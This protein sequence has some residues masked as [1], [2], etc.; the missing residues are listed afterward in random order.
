[1]LKHMTKRISAL[2]LILAFITSTLTACASSNGGE[3][4]SLFETLTDWFTSESEED[5]KGEETSGEE[6]GEEN[7]GE[8]NVT[9][10]T[11][12]LDLYLIA[13]QSNAAGC[14]R[15]TDLNAAYAWSSEL[16]DGFSNVLYAGNSRSNGAAP[17]D[18]VIAW[19]KTTMGLGIT[20]SNYFGPEA[21]MAVALSDYY[22]EET[23]KFAG[24]IKYAYG[25]SSLLN[26]T[27]DDTSKDGN[28]V[29]PSY[30]KT[31]PASQVVGATGQMYRNFLEQVR[32]NVEEVLGQSGNMEEY[33]FDSVRICGLYWMQ[34]CQ[35]K[36]QPD[37]YEKAFKYF[38]KDIRNDLSAIMK[39]ITCSDDDCGATDMPIIVGTISNTQNLTSASTESVNRT[40]IS[41][42]KSFASKIENC[43]VVDNSSYVITKWE[44]NR[45]VVVGSDQWHWN[46]TDMLSIGI[47][48]GEKML[49]CAGHNIDE[50]QLRIV[51]IRNAGQLLA[52]IDESRL[53]NYANS[54]KNTVYQLQNDIDLNEGWSAGVTAEG[55]VLTDLPTAPDVIWTGIDKFYGTLD[56]NGYTVKGIYM[57]KKLDS[58]SSMGFI[59]E[60]CGGTVRNLT[61]DNCYI[62]ASVDSSAS[63]VNIGV[64][65]G[66]ADASSVIDHVTV[67]A[68][69]YI[70]GNENV[71]ASGTVAG[72]PAG[73]SI[74]SSVVFNGNVYKSAEDISIIEV[75]TA[76][77][78]LSALAVHGDFG[79][80]T[81]KLMSNI[82]LNPGWN[83]GVTIDS[84]VNAPST[85]TNLWPDIAVFKGT[86][87]GNGYTLSGIYS[88]KTVSQNGA[89]MAVGGLFNTL[90]G[91]TV[92]NIKIVNSFIL[93]E[94]VGWGNTSLHVGGIAG[95]VNAG[96]TVSCVYFD[97]EI[98][99]KSW[100][101]CYL[102]GIF[103]FANGQYT[104]NGLVFVGRIGYTGGGWDANYASSTAGKEMYISK[105]IVD[106]NFYS[107]ATIT[108]SLMLGS[109]Y[110]KVNKADYPQHMGIYGNPQHFPWSLKYVLLEKLDAAWLET[111]EDYM[112]AGFV[113]SENLGCCIPGEVIELVKDIDA[114]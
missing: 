75:Y 56:G 29:S 12:T 98:W 84:K 90:D 100:D 10:K 63:N 60:L 78:L 52:I 55:S 106:Q 31:L 20:S 104:I 30:Q 70:G 43:Y 7:N 8:E 46:Q 47:N 109:I 54:S 81:L 53:G 86:L 101:N 44:N 42:Q 89:K 110:S 80:K 59:G 91:G 17:R 94:N 87:D 4:D 65:A 32:T 27:S 24:I 9:P 114:K 11:K 62:S 82:D 6:T 85:P 71:N 3:G 111:R 107:D 61:I 39:D 45:Q 50:D 41:M 88:Y 74:E 96:S 21:G 112:K 68:T 1:M 103:G 93:V 79:G 5:T 34:G 2:L 77:E 26:K 67:N 18:R 19:Q 76:E 69:V 72:K 57:Y 95:D 38:S 15:I 13:G 22:N 58:D 99:H 25:G 92:T 33:G 28:W 51:K 37:E 73:S 105:I 36:S 113:Y 108:N 66:V 48:V 102:G 64:I 40:F 49:D 23:G 14:T 35:D 97:A 16:Q 83:A